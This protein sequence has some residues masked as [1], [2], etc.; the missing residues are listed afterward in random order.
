M[1]NMEYNSVTDAAETPKE[2]KQTI[3]DREKQTILDRENRLKELDKSEGVFGEEVADEAMDIVAGGSDF[4][5]LPG[6][7]GWYRC[8]KCG[9]IVVI[10]RS[11]GNSP[12]HVCKKNDNRGFEEGIDY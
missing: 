5:Y 1:K 12:V 8:D 11:I 2:T 9:T 7:S 3:L 4:H 10:G 6:T